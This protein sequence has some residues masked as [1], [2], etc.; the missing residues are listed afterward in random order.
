MI[1]VTSDSHCYYDTINQQIM[2]AESELGIEIDCVIHLGDFGVYASHLHDFFIKSGKR[3]L[4]PLYFIDGNHED[5]NAMPRLIK[6]YSSYFTYLP[7][8]SVHSIHGYRFLALGGAAYM[9]SM[10]TESS[11]IITDEQIN[12]CLGI[13]PDQVDIIITHDCPTDLGVPNTPGMQCYG[14]P[15]FPRSDELAAHFNPRLW[16]F[17]HHH[18]WFSHQSGSTTYQGLCGTWKGF[19]LLD[20]EYRFSVIRHELEWQKSSLIER[21]LVKLRIIRPDKPIS[22]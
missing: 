16:F 8:S 22:S 11:A 3:F 7:R 1:L 5:F 9:D 21:I 15:G 17:G 14:T 12:Q 19:V 18:K 6:K 10:I 20:S 2:Y 13:S 4:K